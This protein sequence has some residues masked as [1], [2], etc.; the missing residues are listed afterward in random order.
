MTQGKASAKLAAADPGALRPPSDP[1]RHSRRRSYAIVAVAGANLSLIHFV[2]LTEFPSLL[3]S[4]E[5]VALIVLGAYFL[6]L[7][8][9]YLVSD[10]ISR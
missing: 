9:G 4:N 5:L 7:S 6:G 2:T 10:K 1:A 3:G 8:A